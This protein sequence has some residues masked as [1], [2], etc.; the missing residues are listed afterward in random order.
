MGISF[1]LRREEQP[2]GC[3]ESRHHKQQL[4]ICCL[5][6]INWQ[7]FARVRKQTTMLLSF[8]SIPVAG[9]I[10]PNVTPISAS[11]R[12]QLQ[13]N[14]HFVIFKFLFIKESFPAEVADKPLVLVCRVD[15][16]DVI[17]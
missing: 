3:F 6:L 8:M 9:V 14:I 13:V 15:A 1:W 5:F 4:S 11:M 17:L 2:V 7:F 12:P 16:P 10:V